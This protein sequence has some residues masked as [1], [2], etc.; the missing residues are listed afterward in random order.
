LPS[1]APFYSSIHGVITRTPAV[2]DSVSGFELLQSG[3]IDR[4]LQFARDKE[5]L[6]D[7]FIACKS[8]VLADSQTPSRSCRKA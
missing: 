5:L 1:H 6:L 4:L 8:K 3:V 7:A 2:W